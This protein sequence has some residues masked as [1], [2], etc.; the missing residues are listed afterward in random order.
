MET[1]PSLGFGFLVGALH[2]RLRAEWAERL[3]HLD[4]TPPAALALRV[5]HRH[6][7]ASLREVA[8]VAGSEPINISKVLERLAVGGLVLVEPSPR[9][10]RANSYQLTAEGEQLLLRVEE[11]M[12]GFAKWLRENSGPVDLET[13]KSTLGELLQALPPHPKS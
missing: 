13:L 5:L 12:L 3:R 6:P 4:L 8:R 9:D 7:G 11:A 10:R 1:D 2:R